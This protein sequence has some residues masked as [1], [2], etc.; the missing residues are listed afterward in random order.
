MKPHDL[1]ELSRE[2]AALTPAKRRERLI[3]YLESEPDPPESADEGASPDWFDQLMAA[4]FRQTRT[5]EAAKRFANSVR[6]RA[7]P[8]RFPSPLLR[9][10]RFGGEE[11][12]AR[13]LAE[14]LIE[15]DFADERGPTAPGLLR[16]GLLRANP[17]WIPGAKRAWARAKSA[18]EFEGEVIFLIARDDPGISVRVLAGIEEARR[19]EGEEASYAVFSPEALSLPDPELTFLVGAALAE[20]LFDHAHYRRLLAD[21]SESATLTILPA[22]VEAAWLRWR[23]KAPLTTDRA[24]LVACGS[25]ATAI[26]ALLRSVLGLPSSALPV[27]DGDLLSEN[28]VPLPNDFPLALPTR[29]EAMRLYA[30]SFLSHP[31]EKAGAEPGVVPFDG[32]KSPALAER[33]GI[34]EAI[35][36]LFP[37]RRPITDSPW[38][39]DLAGALAAAGIMVL[40]ADGNLEAVE[41]RILIESLFLHF[42]DEPETLLQ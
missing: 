42:T 27:D 22:P 13:V 33:Q 12:E 8:L 37:L 9:H 26:R 16:P 11:K 25:L 15:S 31:D 40:A 36:R 41:T 19:V 6:P 1:R 23:M 20:M 38:A 21:R 4:S 5:G 7:V 39:E 14:N 29:F 18:L 3:H 30:E 28:A 17:E 24:G 2:L 35:E 10:L 34:D 32:E